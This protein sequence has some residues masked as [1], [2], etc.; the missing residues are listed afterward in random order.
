MTEDLSYD[1]KPELNEGQLEDS[2]LRNVSSGSWDLLEHFTF[3]LLFI[4]NDAT[5][6]FQQKFK[7]KS[8]QNP[9]SLKIYASPSNLFLALQPEI[10][11]QMN[12]N[13]T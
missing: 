1:L 4:I 3:R 13:M 12:P 9:R 7:L 10:R 11:A 6:S 2:E 8:L 5:H